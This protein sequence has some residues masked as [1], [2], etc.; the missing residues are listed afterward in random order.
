MR[1]RDQIL[2]QE[3]YQ[4]I[5]ENDITQK[6]TSAK[7]SIPQIAATF[8]SKNIN[9]DSN[10]GKINADIGGGAF[11][12]GTNFLKEKGVINVV[13]DPFTRSSEHNKKALELISNGKS[14]TF[15]VNNVLNVI[16]EPEIRHQVIKFAHSC[17]KDEG[18]GYFLIHQG[19]KEDRIKGSRETIKGWQNFLP[20]KAY[21]DE[22][23][24][25]FPNITLKGN[26]FTVKK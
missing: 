23:K 26:I 20:A 14:D 2:L 21:Y 4:I 15:T 13:Y 5:C 22:I 7:T 16:M 24:K 1:D 12:L 11:D 18:T 8:K 19:S 10:K 9:W 3:A 6:Y 17:L 25:V